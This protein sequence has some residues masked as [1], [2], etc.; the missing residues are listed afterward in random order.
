M[1]ETVERTYITLN[2]LQSLEKGA[3]SSTKGSKSIIRNLQY[4]RE[5]LFLFIN[6]TTTILEPI[7]F[8]KT[9]N[10][11]EKRRDSLNS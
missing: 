2:K 4:I 7:V 5:G 10:R 1:L 11:N 3:T 6:Q 9:L 8:A